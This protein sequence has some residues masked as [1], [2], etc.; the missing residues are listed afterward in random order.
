MI[1]ASVSRTRLNDHDWLRQSFMIPHR[2]VAMSGGNGQRRG[3]GNASETDAQVRTRFFTHASLKFS[4][5]TPGGNLVLNPHPQFTK[6]TDPRIRGIGGSKY[7]MGR[8]YSDNIDDNKRYI[9][10]CVGTAQYNSLHNF[11]TGFYNSEAAL[12][13]RTG[14][15]NSIFYSAGRVAGFIVG[16]FSPWL[17]A[18]SV[19]AATYRYAMDKSQTKYYFFK[20]AMPMFWN[21]ATMVANELATKTGL[22][23]SVIKKDAFSTMDNR[24]VL[25]PAAVR[26]INA[27]VP[28]IIDSYDEATGDGNGINLYAIATR[29]SR[30]ASRSF[31]TIQEFYRG[32]ATSDNVQADVSELLQEIRS[33]LAQAARPSKSFHQYLK[34]W[35]GSGPGT[36]EGASGSDGAMNVLYSSENS[37]N[38]AKPDLLV[39]YVIGANKEDAAERG[40]SW[41]DFYMAELNDGALYFSIRVDT[42]GTVGESTSTNTGESE[43]QSK[44]NSMSGSARS[45]RFNFMEGNVA[46]DT[47]IGDAIQGAIGLAKE[48]AMGVA[49]S[50][51]FGGAAALGGNAFVDIPKVVTGSQTQLPTMSYQIKLRSP[52]GNRWSRFVN[53]W[54][55]FSLL[56]TMSMPLSTGPAS[57]TGPFYVQCFDR[58]RAQTRLGVVTNFQVTRGTTNLGWNRIGE[59]MGIDLSIEITELSSICHLPISSGFSPLDL[60]QI[61]DSESLF[62]D[63]M[64]VLSSLSLQEQ[65]YVGERLKL[66]FTKYMKNLDSWASVPHAMNWAGDFAISRIIAISQPGTIN[67]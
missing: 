9:T 30:M 1:N 20:A 17:V 67:R 10:F 33:E 60:K 43:V 22:I 48:F 38:I 11:W 32:R 45:T 56:M 51:G 64:S 29:N 65:V 58:G 52:Y 40:Q 25:S 53:I 66:S 3:L 28:D 21:A 37:G 2:V 18:F 55:P 27:Q 50:L 59:P 14:R 31:R 12:A 63:Y 26:E 42:V 16:L 5:T 61:F 13:A 36:V 47:G 6:Y 7:G 49:D 4:D 54:M 57:Y 34:E 19:G 46:G 24:D 23:T 62:N 35:I 15:S 41:T 39:D 44:F 8:W